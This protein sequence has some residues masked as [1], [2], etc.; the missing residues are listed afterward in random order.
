MLISSVVL[1]GHTRTVLYAGK[2]KILLPS[3][4]KEG[5]FLLVFCFFIDPQ[6]FLPTPSVYAAH[7][8]SLAVSVA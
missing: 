7:L 8:V 3:M 1:D 2:S 4:S 5:E 6:V